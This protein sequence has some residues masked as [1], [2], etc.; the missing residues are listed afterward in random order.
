MAARKFHIIPVLHELDW[1][2]VHGVS[3][4]RFNLTAMSVFKCLNRVALAHLAVDCAPVS[5]VASRWQHL[6]SADTWS[7]VL[8][9][10]RTPLGA[11]DFAL[12]SAVVWNSLHAAL[13]VASL[14]VKVY[15]LHLL[16]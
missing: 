11:R 4:I 5:S 8:Q 15:L 13:R 9:Q 14:T 12:S 1:P 7:L 10:T 3:R 16:L 6:R 2:P